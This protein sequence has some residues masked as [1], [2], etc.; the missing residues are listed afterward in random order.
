MNVTKPKWTICNFIQSRAIDDVWAT[1]NQIAHGTSIDVK[2][3]RQLMPSLVDAGYLQRTDN[4]PRLYRWA[5]DAPPLP[6]PRSDRV[7]RPTREEREQQIAEA[8]AQRTAA[9]VNEM[10]RFASTC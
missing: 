9:A 8:A 5:D 1:A 3:V 7:R 10:V 2:H 4:C 6:A